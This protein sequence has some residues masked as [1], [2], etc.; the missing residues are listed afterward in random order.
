MSG[1]LDHVTTIRGRFV[2]LRPISRE[3]Y[4]TL[5]RWRSS[6]STIH[7]LNF[8]R[9]V[10]TYEEFVRELEQML[11]NVILLLIRDRKTAAPIG[12][13]LGYNIQPWD[14]YMGGS[15][16]IEPGR[17]MRVYG[18]EAL[19]HSIDFFFSLFP[20]NKIVV[21]PYEFATTLRAM[22]E[23]MGFEECGVY[24]DHY[25]H[26]GKSWALHVMA[27][28]RE[29]WGIERERYLSLIDTENFLSSHDENGA[30]GDDQIGSEV[31]I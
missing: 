30:R 13:T 14:R 19:V 18:G 22:L 10:S 1:S 27:L 28:H 5:F 11:P 24:T 31:A 20:I 6:F 21:E 23:R 2:E 8:R 25:W 4:P 12:Y 9:S 3:D 29:R 15:I 7:A 26:D 17:R 16:F